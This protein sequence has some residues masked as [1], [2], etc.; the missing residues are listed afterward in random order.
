[1]MAVDVDSDFVKE[2]VYNLKDIFM[3]GVKF[4]DD[5]NFRM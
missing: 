1:M 4:V 5:V 3:T 2:I